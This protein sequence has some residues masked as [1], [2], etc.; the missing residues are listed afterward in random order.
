MQQSEIALLWRTLCKSDLYFLLRFG[1]DRADCDTDWV[2]NRCREVQADPDYR[3]DLWAREHYKST[4]VT[5]ALT[6]QDILNDPEQTF[7]IFSH[8]RGIAK[9]F[10]RQIMRELESN[11]V[12]QDLFPEVLWRAPKTEAPTWSED[13]GIVVRRNGNPKEATIEAWGL[14]DGQP[15][16]KHF[17]NRIYDDVVVKESVATPEQIRKVTEAWEMSLNL[18]KAA[19]GGPDVARYVGTTYHYHDTY[20]EIAKRKSAI[21]RVYP[22]TDDGTPTGNPVM[23]SA[24]ALSDRR[25]DMGPYT[26]ATQMLLDPKADETQGF[27][28]KWLRHYE[29]EEDGAGMNIY[30][31]VDPAHAKKKNSDYTAMWV[32]GLSA[33]GNYYILDMVR[34]RLNLEQ[35]ADAVFELHRRYSKPGRPVKAVGYERY[36]LQADIEH[37]QYRQKI[38]NYR[39][40][41]EELGGQ[42]AKSDR[43]KRMM[44]KFEQ[45]LVWLPEACPKVNYEGQVV[46]LVRY[47][48][49]EEYKP[50]PV[51]AY[52]DMLDSLARIVDADLKVVWPRPTG[53]SER[54]DRYAKKSRGYG[55]RGGSR[56]SSAWA[57]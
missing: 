38:E 22:A 52:D 45:G 36:G 29:G 25:R 4:I 35:R 19:Q 46:E 15:T 8:T 57:A 3:I 43:I 5:F 50:F 1:C 54:D 51:C 26:F 33:D 30:I 2:F 12:L 53:E 16:S 13:G 31:L 34:D 55:R 37:L 6:I 40:N 24:Q 14:V 28:E 23:M 41:I 20:A 48:V 9:G 44:P 7:G 10:L 39:F 17:D 47:F 32:I 18:G 49:E 11:L 42:Q 21:P 56:R 27:L